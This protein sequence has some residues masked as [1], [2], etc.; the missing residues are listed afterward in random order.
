VTRFEK[1]TA[2]SSKRTAYLRQLI[3]DAQADGT[4]VVVWLTALHP[5][6]ERHLATST[7]YGPLLSA[8]RDALISLR[9]DLDVPTFDFS[10]PARYNGTPDGWYDCAHIDET[11][12]E[13]V[14]ASL[15]DALR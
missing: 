7:S 11:N 12:A 2:L 5:A 10:S 1:M 8:A 9:Q 14:A 13:R 6:T 3:D 15:A 4:K